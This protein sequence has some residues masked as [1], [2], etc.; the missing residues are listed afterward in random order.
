MN[1][2]HLYKKVH[3]YTWVKDEPTKT[4][5]IT[6]IGYPLLQLIFHTMLWTFHL[7]AIIL[8]DSNQI[9]SLDPNYLAAHYHRLHIASSFWFVVV[10]VD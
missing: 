7:S 2:H 3:D 5:I 8:C 1:R 9:V 10:L 4:I 6:A